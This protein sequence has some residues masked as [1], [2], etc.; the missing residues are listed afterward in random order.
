MRSTSCGEGA[1]KLAAL[2]RFYPIGSTAAAGRQGSAL[3]REKAE[4]RADE[5]QR[6]EAFE[7]AVG[8]GAVGQEHVVVDELDGRIAVIAGGVR[9]EV[10]HVR[11][12]LP[13]VMRDGCR[14]RRALGVGAAV[15]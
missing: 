13:V 14:E 11:P 12:R 15:V 5:L 6:G 3:A 9:F 4:R 8:A 2:A 10:A 1:G 7:H